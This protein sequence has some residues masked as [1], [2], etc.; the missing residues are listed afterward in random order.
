ML[1]NNQNNFLF[2]TRADENTELHLSN[3]LEETIIGIKSSLQQLATRSDFDITIQQ[4][5]GNNIDTE[6]VKDWIA[7]ESIFPAIE[8]VKA[9]EK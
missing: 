3:L 2:S 8:I 7:V 1:V 9:V 4:A 6:L 5:F